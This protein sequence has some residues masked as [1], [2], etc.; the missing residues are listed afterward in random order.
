VI[1]AGTRLGAY[2]ILAP[3]GAGGMGEV[4]K[5]RDTK[6][7]RDVAIKVLPA[8][9]RDDRE[10]LGRFEREAKAVA[11]LSHPN[12][13]AIFDFGRDGST[14]YAVTELLEGESLRTALAG[15]KLPLRKAVE[16][17]LQIARGL[18]AAHETGIV[19][20]DLKPENVFVTRDGRVK[21]LDF[22][23]AKP[24]RTDRGSMITNLP[25]ETAGTEPGVV[26][27]TLGYMSPEQVKGMAVDPRS[28][29]FS[30]GALLY[31]MLSGRRAFQSGSAAET[32]SAIL[33]EE[34]PPLSESGRALPPPLERLV[35]HCLE[36]SPEVRFQSAR[37]LA[38][39]LEALSGLT[40][41]TGFSAVGAG[42]AG[43]ERR[44][45]LAAAGALAVVCAVGGL[46]AAR[47]L[48]KPATA[49]AS[50]QRLTFRRGLVNSARFAPDGQTV[51]YGAEWDGEASQVFLKRPE[52]FDALA[53]DL[54]PAVVLSVSRSSE[55]ALLLNCTVGRG[56]CPGTLA[57]AS[58]TGGTPRRLQENV[59]SADYA[60][61]GQLALVRRVGGRTWLEF[62]PGKVLYETSGNITYPRFSPKGDRI[63][64]ID[65]PLPIDDRGA[66]AVIDLAG[67]KKTLSRVWASARGTG[68]SPSGSEIWFSGG[69]TLE[70]QLRA[71]SLTGQE[72]LLAS[73]P[74]GVALCDIRPDGRVLV[75]S[76]AQG[77]A[78]IA[79]APGESREKNLTWY[80][81][82]IASDLSDDGMTILF[83]EEGGS[84]G[85]NYGSCLRRMDGSAPV[86]L[87]EG[88]AQSLSSD[89]QWVLSQLPKGDASN[90][91][92]PTGAGK[93]RPLPTFGLLRSG[94]ATFFPDGKRILLAAQ[95]PGHPSRLWIQD[96]EGGQPRPVTP[97]GVTRPYSYGVHAVSPDGSRFFALDA[98]GKLGIYPIGGGPMQPVPAFEPAVERPIRWS[99]DGRF[100][101]VRMQRP[102]ALQVWRIDLTTGRKELWR[103]L[104]QADPAGVVGMVS[105][106]L[107]PDGRAYAYTPSRVLSALFL[108]EGLR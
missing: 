45:S 10:A 57:V 3:L 59:T 80:G 1:A 91:I 5:A 35:H 21:I 51:V 83:T 24:A 27:G 61:D 82:S 68:W 81:H 63:A 89:G 72:R 48:W 70:R 84:A 79:V 36:K 28:D 75:T 13:L 104:T 6:L 41:S 94:M 76:E 71:A 31:E 47:F 102:P 58:L 23:L 16:Y 65:N 93:P 26:L 64:F 34:P 14:A 53:L 43:R 38:Y 88:F 78:L 108:V 101:F 66:L 39:D 105:L 46:V 95:E 97:E 18:A 74:T 106:A 7:D 40:P 2:E 60:P 15:G 33:K 85:P 50:Y 30:F 44:V 37:D 67:K 42:G 87:G 49:P 55:L 11:A 92:L 77:S 69:E 103:D 90:V 54:P 32:M 20:R 98:G 86:R 25:T 12:I 9:L 8:R 56:V 107:S 73:L 17:A 29:I 22:G 19:H 62:P 52:S 99:A 4:W 96:V 100:L